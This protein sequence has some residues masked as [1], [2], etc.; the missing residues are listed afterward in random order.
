MSLTKEK[1]GVDLPTP[2]ID[3]LHAIPREQRE[4]VQEFIDWLYDE[5]HWQIGEYP[6][7][8]RDDAT[9]SPRMWPV[10]INRANIMGMFF[11]IDDEKVSQEQTAVYEALYGNNGVMKEERL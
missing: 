4:I 7:M 9:L 1:D 6:P 2:E 5:M 11:E 8:S 3:K 10:L